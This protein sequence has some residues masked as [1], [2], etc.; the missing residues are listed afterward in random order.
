[1]LK[2]ISLIS[3]LVLLILTNNSV[4]S[5]QDTLFWFAAPEVSSSEGDSPVYLRFMTYDQP[6]TITTSLPANGGFTPI[7]TVLPANSIDSINLTPFLADIESSSANAINS[8]GIK[9]SSTSFISC[10]YNL[11][12]AGNKELFS[13]K[14]NKGLGTNFYTPFQKFWDNAST[15]PST[16]SSIEIVSSLDGTTVLISPK[17]DVVGH[18]ANSTFSITL[19]EGETFSVRDVDPLASTSLAGSI[20]SSNNPIAVTCFSGALSQ[21]SCT[22]TVGDQITPTDYI[23]TDYIINKGTSNDKVFVLATQNATSIDVFGASTTNTLINWGETYEIDVTDSVMYINT[24]KPVYVFHVSGNGCNLSGAQVPNVFCSGKYTQTFTRTNA[25]S[26]GLVL[27]VRS[28]FENQ[29]LLNGTSTLIQASSFAPVPGTSGD[30]VAA[31]IYLSI[32]DIPVDSYNLVENLGDVFGM[33]TIEGQSG[34]GSGFA[35]MSEFLSYPYVDA[36]AD[37]TVCANVSFPVNGIVGGGSVT[38]YWSG[39]GFG[40]FQ[41]TSTDLSNTYIPSG[42]DTIISPIELILT[43]SGPCPIQR[44]T[45]LLYVDP[46]PIVNASADQSVCANNSNVQLSG[47]ISG[48]AHT[49]VWTSTGTGVFTPNDSTLNSVY[50]PSPSDTIA[51]SV[52]LILTSANVVSCNNVSDTM[53]VM[54]TPAPTVDSGADST[55]ACK[56][57][58]TVSLNGSVSGGSSTGKWL[59]TG[60][61]VFSPDNLTLNATYTPSAADIQS[62]SI[63]LIL[64]STSNGGCLPERDTLL[65]MFTNA[66]QTEAGANILACTNETEVQLNGTVSGPTTSGVWSGGSGT[67]NASSSDLNALYTPTAAEISAGSVVLTLT[68]TNNGTCTAVSDAVQLD[69]V[70]PPLANFTGTDVCLGEETEFTDFSLNG[71]GTITNWDWSFGNGTTDTLQEPLL[72]YSQAGTY[73]VSLIVTTNVGCEDTLIQDVNVYETPISDFS[74]SANCSGSSTTVDFFDNASANGDT[75]NYWF[76]DFGGQGNS[77]SPNTSNTFVG[78]GDFVITQIVS[79]VHNCVDS[80]VQIVEIPDLPNAGFYYNTDNGLNIGA[81]FNF[82]DTSANATSF[83]WTFDDGN[84]STQQDPSNVYY[85][86]GSYVVTQYAYNNVG[87][88][89]SSL[90]LITIN[91]VT[92]E[93]K[94]LIPNAISPNGDGKNDVWKLKFVQLLYPEA[95]VEIFNRWGQLLFRSVGYSTP[96]DGTFNGERVPDGTYYYVLNLNDESEPE[97]YKGTI[98]VLKNQD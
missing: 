1:M 41:N 28:G 62:N 15:T 44:D 8:N 74:F 46:A 33:G 52:Q 98:L 17:T 63:Y 6:A 19:D 64:E 57:N 7:T 95:E 91:T 53:N 16:F 96:W 5:Q 58:A 34:S 36:G 21:N 22:S 89:D 43:S 94:Q 54:I 86:N 30:F 48:G 73:S 12:A 88:V 14:G 4:V 51:G 66:P 60:N 79:T 45:L 42:L 78:T 25:D 3:T 35:Y 75:I 77:T 39:T 69:F 70:A 40:S 97:P 23:G 10:I 32:A 85:T 65:V 56:N 83:Y 72:T 49:G 82:V 18:S 37:D 13:L 20:I 81:T 26:L 9:I 38:G 67:F 90:A 71:Y 55:Y 87:C 50:V 29:F 59:T 27:Y 84:S 11:E 61:G 2:G 24:S 76:Y 31:T 93:I 80:L 92:T 68:S 47:S